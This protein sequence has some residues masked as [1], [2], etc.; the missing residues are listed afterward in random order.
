MLPSILILAATAAGAALANPHLH[1]PTAVIA[2]GVVVGTTT[3][4]PSARATV[5]Q[6]LG[7]PF[8]ISPPERFG[9]PLPPARFRGQLDASQFKDSCTQQFNCEF[10]FNF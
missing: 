4:L 10:K 3:S 8:A 5:N 2:E 7:I 9:L 6:F 1:Q